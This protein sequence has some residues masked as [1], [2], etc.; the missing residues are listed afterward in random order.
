MKAK[1]LTALSLAAPM[2]LSA[3]EKPNI[4]WIITDDHRADALE[5]WNKATTGKSESALGYVSS[6]NINKLAEEGVLFTRSFCNSP[7]SAPSRASMHT[8]KYPHHNG[9]PA[10]TLNHNQNDFCNPL[11]TEVMSEA[12]YKTTL[13]G[14]LGTR[15]CNTP[16]RLS[17]GTIKIYDA[18]VGMEGDLERVGI[19]D[20]G[21]KTLYG[22][23]E[24]HGSVETWYF[25]DGTE[26]SYYQQRKNAE[27]TKEDIA[28]QAE[29]D[30][31]LDIIRDNK[32]GSIL[33][34]VSPMP[35]EKTLDGRIAEEAMNYLKSPNEKYKILRGRMM[36]G[37]NTS[38]PQFI[39]LG[40]HFPHTA[41]IPSKEYRDKFMNLDYNVPKLTEDEWEKMPAQVRSWYKYGQIEHLNNK[42][43]LQIIRDYY[44]FCAM[45]D[46]LLGQVVDEFKAY[47]KKNNQEYVILFVCGDH[48]WHLGEQ[49]VCRKA[50]GYI[51]SNETAV[52]AVSSYDKKTFPAGK[53]VSDFVEYVD[54]YPTFMELA[55]IDTEKADYDY[56]DGRSLTFTTTGKAE[57]R[58][59]V[60]GET[61]VGGGPRAWIRGEDF[62]FSMRIR[63]DWRAP[64]DK[65]RPNKDIMWGLE[66]P[67]E[68]ISM[69]LFDRRVDPTEVNNV[70]Y[71]KEYQELAD[72][73]RKKL[74]N[75][76]LGDGRVEVN[77]PKKNDYAISTFAKGS[78]DKKLDIPSNIIP[79]VT[80]S[81]KKKK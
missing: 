65:C 79:S 30:K 22:K 47:C 40:F 10:F 2:L 16:E 1:L 35:T 68:D 26:K 55:G 5:C 64:S 15:I 80:T 31:Q 37:P 59:Y 57:P 81:K 74:C 18:S 50:S 39:N 73:F 53:V 66:A 46:A 52:I 48:G 36:D 24:V 32:N 45:G 21:R 72:W 51:K 77:W 49:G 70:A 42:Q 71:T 61:S 44:A 8:G 12:G 3:A 69:A 11:L 19:T 20:V 27:R 60:I 33:G 23:D 28:T 76:V 25:P 7:V 67:R 43:K 17:F 13:F 4:L 58:E 29:V 78:D 14:K 6:P 75:I 9:I 54:F 63:E 62:A 34:G 41:V 56:L 38:Q